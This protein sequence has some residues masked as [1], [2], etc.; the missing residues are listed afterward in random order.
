MAHHTTMVGCHGCVTS[1]M[2]VKYPSEK[3]ILK[4]TIRMKLVLI[5][6]F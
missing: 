3:V 5:K 1:D 2:N 6:V 4:V